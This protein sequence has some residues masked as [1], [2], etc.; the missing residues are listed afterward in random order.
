VSKIYYFGDVDR[1]GLEIPHQLARDLAPQRILLPLISAYEFLFR[2]TASG[3]I[4]IPES[5]LWLPEP[6]A[7]SAATII[8]GGNRIPQEAFGWEEIATQYGINP[9]S[10]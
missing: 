5:C 2:E 7:K 1:R 3:N 4:P 8:A 9:F 10:N 6:L